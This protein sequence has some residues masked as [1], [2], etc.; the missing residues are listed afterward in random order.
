MYNWI[1]QA[2]TWQTEVRLFHL[3]MFHQQSFSYVGTGLSWLNQ[4]L[5]RINMSCSRTQHSD[6]GEA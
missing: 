5:A 2:I 3:I 6:A 4:Y 1:Q